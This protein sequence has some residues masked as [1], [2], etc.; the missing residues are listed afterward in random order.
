LNCRHRVYLLGKFWVWAATTRSLPS[1]SL[2]FFCF[3]WGCCCFSYLWSWRCHNNNWNK[4]KQIST[5]WPRASPCA[6]FLSILGGRFPI[7]FGCCG[8]MPE[9][10]PC[11][12]LSQRLKKDKKLCNCC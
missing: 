10:S 2:H 3:S 6:A 4:K 11:I 12:H 5:H 9:S 1:L 7:N 8:G